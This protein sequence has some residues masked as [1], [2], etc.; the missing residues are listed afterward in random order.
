MN[1]RKT[2]LAAV[3]VVPLTLTACGSD[4]ENADNAAT[5][6]TSQE[7][8]TSAKPGEDNKDAKEGKDG[9]ESESS[10]PSSGDQPDAPE[11][12]GADRPA[13][14]APA[15]N[16][17]EGR[18]GGSNGR[19]APAGGGG[20]ND[21]EAITRLVEG[22][23]DGGN[24]MQALAYYTL[25]NSC[26]AYINSRGGEAQLRSQADGMVDPATGKPL[27]FSDFEKMAR[28]A[29]AQ[30][31]ANMGMAKIQKVEN[32]NVTGDR[33]TAFVTSEQNA[34]EMQFAREGGQWK[35]CPAG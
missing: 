26:T 1:Y 35:I 3:L 21:T 6:A 33:A 5:S 28:E 22:L 7:S 24:N 12:E 18:E 13:G 32:V 9:K 30:V 20:G 34:T 11:R 14:A 10:K 17:A 19:P 31:P 15:P 8:S 2:L 25:D 23:D 29:G 16:N 4:E 27:N